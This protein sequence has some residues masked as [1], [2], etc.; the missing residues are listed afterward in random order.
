MATLPPDDPP[1]ANRKTITLQ[2]ALP[3]IVGM[4]FLLFL[5]AT[6]QFRILFDT[7]TD[8]VPGARP[9]SSYGFNLEPCLI[10]HEELIGTIARKGDVPPLNSPKTLSAE[11]AGQ[12]ES[13][14]ARFRPV[15]DP[16]VKLGDRV[17]GL[18]L[19]GA[20]RA[21]PLWVLAAHEVCN[22]ILDGVPVAVTYSPLCDSAVVFDRRVGSRVLSLAAS[23][24]I[25][26]SNSLLFD[27][28]PNDADESLWLQIQA[29]A[30][31]GVS[32]ARGEQLTILPSY[33]TTWEGWKTAHPHTDVIAREPTRNKFY[34]PNAFEVYFHDERLR[35]P[36]NPR[37]GARFPLKTPMVALC[38]KDGWVVHRAA[39]FDALIDLNDRPVIYA[40][41]FAWSSIRGYQ[42]E[43]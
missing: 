6:W 5:L 2:G 11:K 20:T 24:L 41:W 25:Y 38:E 16:V 39:D 10:P 30:V 18:N 33:L 1:I 17:V 12:L 4:G 27:D 22:D 8:S 9:A 42:V 13:A 23:G 31:S 29:R 43:K 15:Q 19:G 21:Y 34:R 35:F 40:F 37:P 14:F 32:A 28:L 3:L 26:N 7:S 36:V